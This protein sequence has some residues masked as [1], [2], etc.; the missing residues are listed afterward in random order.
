MAMNTNTVKTNTPMV[1]TME[2]LVRLMLHAWIHI[3]PLM[4]TYSLQTLP[5]NIGF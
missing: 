5:H 3:I 2:N 1:V 4:V